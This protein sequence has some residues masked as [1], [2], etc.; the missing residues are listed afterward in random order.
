MIWGGAKTEACTPLA[1]TK[2]LPVLFF[3]CIAVSPPLPL[4]FSKG[5]EICISM[6]N[7]LSLISFESVLSACCDLP[8]GNG[9]FCRGLEGFKSHL[10]LR[11][12]SPRSPTPLKS[13]FP[14]KSYPKKLAPPSA[15]IYFAHSHWSSSH[16]LTLCATTV[17]NEINLFST[18]LSLTRSFLLPLSPSLT[19]SS[20]S[21][22][23]FMAAIWK[24][25]KACRQWL[26]SNTFGT[27]VTRNAP[28]M[29]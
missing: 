19:P 9:S 1:R 14:S 20:F 29:H 26:A 23:S 15:N 22:T 2:P 17:T 3:R 10:G 12:L 5:L 7:R 28:W 4:A 8:Q 13:F 24:E 21:S 11:F 25:S 18:S 6:R 27:K 16:D